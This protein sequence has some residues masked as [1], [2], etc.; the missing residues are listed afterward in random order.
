MDTSK[1]P[2]SRDKKV[3]EGSVNAAKGSS[4]HTNGPVGNGPRESA[5][6]SSAPG[7]QKGASFQTGGVRPATGGTSRPYGASSAPSRGLLSGFMALPKKLRSIIL[8]IVAVIVLVYLFKGCSQ[9]EEYYYDTPSAPSQQ[10]TVQQ[11]TAAPV[12]QQQNV[13]QQPTAVPATAAP[14][15]Q[16][17]AAA[18]RSKRYMPLGNG[19]DTVTVMVY[20]CGTD[21]ESNYK[22]ATSDL[23]EMVSATISPK[24]NLIVETGG[25]KRWANSIV[26]NATNQIYKVETGGLRLVKDGLGKKPMVDPSTLTDFID[27]CEENYPADRNILIF[28]DHGGGSI[29][30]YGHDELF[31]SAGSMDLSE[32]SEALM[33]ADCTFDWI[34]FDACLMATLETALVCNEY[35]DYLVASEETEPGTGWYYTNWL[36]ALSKNTSVSTEQLAKIII[37]DFVKSSCQASSSAQVT[38]SLVDLAEMQGTVPA[39]LNGFSTSTTELLQTQNYSAVSNARAGVRQFAKSSRLNQIDLVDFADR[40]GTREASQL[41]ESLRSCIKYNNSTISRAYG[42]SIYFPYETTNSMSS[43]VSTYNKLDFDSDYTN[44]IKSFA[45]LASSGQLVSSSSSGYGSLGGLLGGGYGGSSYSSAMDT[46]DIASLFGGGSSPLG[47]LMGLYSGSSGVPSSG[48]SIDPS[49]VMGLLSAFSGRSMP[50][51]C[52]WVDTETI[53]RNAEY[54]SENMLDP[55]DIMVTIRPDGKRVLSLTEEQWELVQNVELNVYVDDGEGYIDLGLDNVFEFDGNDLLLDYDGTWLTL[56]GNL[57]AY[58]L[59]SDTEEDDGSYTTRGRIPALLNGQLVD[60]EVVFD[61]ENPYGVI[62]GARP[63]YEEE[64]TPLAKGDIEIAAGDT[65]QPLCDYYTYDGEYTSTYTLGEAFTVGN[66]LVLENLALDETCSVTYR[67]TDIYSAHYWTPA[68]VWG[69]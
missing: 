17:V 1:K 62:T 41:A 7:S 44:C 6:P 12:Q 25:C 26:S 27:F 39:A 38:L 9:Q 69:E 19:M 34:G 42:L 18:G 66:E 8:L 52:D 15:A 5:K 29:T 14:S 37:D 50:A 30:G 59:V 28:W 64:N 53:A 11:P 36:T 55:G 47:S 33:N 67:L 16:S 21:L 40:V 24:V 65:I 45:S 57:V 58:Y 3:G 68:W 2:H 48:Y 46:M 43:A 54:I 13:P 20:M 61:D 23:Q 35:A 10:Q 4:V 31:T 32:I 60:L 63:M 56:N 51:E 49:A 22:M